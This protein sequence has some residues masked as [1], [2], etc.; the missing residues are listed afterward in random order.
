MI[1][2]DDP[3][4]YAHRC[5]CGSRAPRGRQR[6]CRLCDPAPFLAHV[7]RWLPWVKRRW[8]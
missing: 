5:R 3:G 4:P 1:Q 6:L 7:F 2:P 8:W